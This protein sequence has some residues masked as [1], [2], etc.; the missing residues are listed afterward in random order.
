M[1]VPDQPH[2]FEVGDRPA[3]TVG[4]DRAGSHKAAERV[5]GLELD[6]L[7]RMER[8]IRAVGDDLLDAVKRCRTAQKH[9]YEDRGIDDDH[10]RS[11]SS[12]IT[13]AED[14]PS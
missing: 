14:G 1:R 11:R 7:R 3:S 12:R 2:S 4:T 6:Q 10:R 5:E 13:D 8:I 9:V